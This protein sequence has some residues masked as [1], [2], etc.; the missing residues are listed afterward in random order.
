MKRSLKSFVNCT[1]SDLYRKWP[2]DNA[3]PS[4][5]QPDPIQTKYG[6]E[7][8]SHAYWYGIERQ[9]FWGLGALQLG[10]LEAAGLIKPVD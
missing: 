7:L 10:T 5:E 4:T 1:M 3:T 2:L 8:L 6:F 9:E